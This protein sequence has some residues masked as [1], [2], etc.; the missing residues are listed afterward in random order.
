MDVTIKNI[1]EMVSETEVKEWVAILI[2][3]KYEQSI[4][5]P[6]EIIETA[7]TNIDVFRKANTL[8]AL[9]EKEIVEEVKEVVEEVPIVK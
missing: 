1:P 9:F 5:P 7:R 4:T 2:Q 6:Q 3:R 8:K